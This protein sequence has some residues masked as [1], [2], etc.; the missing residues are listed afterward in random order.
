MLVIASRNPALFR[1]TAIRLALRYAVIYAV[2]MG[3]ALAIL[4][5]TTARLVG[6]VHSELEDELA[7][8]RT[9]YDVGPPRRWRKRSL[10]RPLRTRADFRS[11]SPLTA[12]SSRVIFYGGRGNRRC[13]WTARS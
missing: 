3:S 9:S 11:C 10:R 6:S 2:I 7:A 1:T 12:T 4:R 13:P 8:L 5:F